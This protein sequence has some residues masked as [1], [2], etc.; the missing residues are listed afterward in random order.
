MEITEGEM[1]DPLKPC[2]FCGQES[3]MFT[4]H[5][6]HKVACTRDCVTMPSMPDISFTSEEAAIKHWNKRAQTSVLDVSEYYKEEA[7]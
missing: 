6:G 3:F 7:E 4:T 5:N 2:P 1:T